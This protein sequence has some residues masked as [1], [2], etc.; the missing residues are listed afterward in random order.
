MSSV[1][2]GKS[3]IESLRDELDQW[4]ESIPENPQRLYFRL[5]IEEAMNEL[6]DLIGMLED[7]EG[8]SVEF[9]GMY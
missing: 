9:P 2:D 1:S 7:V 3:E 4:K 5:S 6:E 8:R